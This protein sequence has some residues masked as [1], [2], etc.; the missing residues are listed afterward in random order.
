M[1]MIICKRSG[2][3][4]VGT[5][6][7]FSLVS[8]SRDSLKVWAVDGASVEEQRLVKSARAPRSAAWN[9]TCAC[10]ALHSSP[11]SDAHLAVRR[12][13]RRVRS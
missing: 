8:F 4:L 7:R 5:M 10:A 9:H 2:I 3:P 11:P 1:A 6:V 13:C 12:P